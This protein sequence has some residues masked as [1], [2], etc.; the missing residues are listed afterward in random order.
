MLKKVVAMMA[1]MFLF[2]AVV[3]CG[4][5]EDE[6]GEPNK[7]KKVKGE[8][9]EKKHEKD[10][11][12]AKEHKEKKEDKEK[13]EAKE[14]EKG[15]LVKEN[16]EKLAALKEELNLS[17]EQREQMKK[18]FHDRREELKPLAK[19]V[20][21]ARRALRDA[22]LAE[23]ADEKSIREA[24]DDLAKAIGDTAIVL[25]GMAGEARKVLTDEQMEILKKF[26]DDKEKS[27]DKHLEKLFDK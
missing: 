4:F 19:K 14:G 6:K 7:E 9:K 24:A 1:V 20:V 17:D 8:E 27:I 18:I 23:K 2:F 26:T 12:Q 5:A 25:S 13:K 15:K 16:L 10:S 22:V 21:K 11:E 3:N